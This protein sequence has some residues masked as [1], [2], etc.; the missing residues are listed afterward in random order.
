MNRTRNIGRLLTLALTVVGL[1]AGLTGCSGGSSTAPPA[2]STN[3]PA[4]PAST[5]VGG[6]G[7][8]TPAPPK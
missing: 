8:P 6:S 5:A 1:T 3:A 4:D 2:V 7:M